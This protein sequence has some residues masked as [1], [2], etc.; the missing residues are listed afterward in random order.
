MVLTTT[1]RRVIVAITTIFLLVLWI[2][3]WIPSKPLYEVIE[4][5]HAHEPERKTH[6]FDLP[7]SVP[8][9][10]RWD[11]YPVLFFDATF[12]IEALRA[13]MKANY[14]FNT[15]DK[16]LI[17]QTTNHPQIHYQKRIRIFM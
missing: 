16:I 15:S 14:K 13:G 11:V 1:Q 12:S 17:L 4:E 7:V 9:K 6:V 5:P 8:V 2:Q 10:K 3:W